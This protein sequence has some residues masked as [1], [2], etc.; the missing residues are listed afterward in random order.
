MASSYVLG[1]SGSMQDAEDI[2][3]DAVVSFIEMAADGRFR[4][5][6]SISSFLYSLTRNRWL[7][8]LRRQSRAQR[9]QQDFN[10]GLPQSPNDPVSQLAERELSAQ[11]MELI[12]T[13][14]E[15]CRT[16][17]LAFYYED[18]PIREILARV[19]YANEQVLRNKKTKC[20]KQLVESLTAQR[21]LL[22]YFKMAFNDER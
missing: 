20:M 10:A 7:N 4:A 8:E 3:Q 9:R 12:G 21:H 13:L 18:L 17:L 2:F 19:D 22:Q 1:N 14:G 16:I 5:E 11:V 15:V 6:S